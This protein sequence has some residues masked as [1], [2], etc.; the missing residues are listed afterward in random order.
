MKERFP[1]CRALYDR[2]INSNYQIVKS[3]EGF[4]LLIENKFLWIKWYTTPRCVSA[5]LEA[6]KILPKLGKKVRLSE[7]YSTEEDVLY[8]YT[9]LLKT[10]HEILKEDVKIIKQGDSATLVFVDSL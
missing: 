6:E 10:L 3:S 8:A 2:L 5:M 9:S 7:V 4:S 1:E